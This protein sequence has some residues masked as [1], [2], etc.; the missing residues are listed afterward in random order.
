M[1]VI[2]DSDI[3]FIKGVI[4]TYCEVVYKK[5]E[6]ITSCDVKDADALIIRTRTKCTRSLLD[7]SNVRFIASATIGSDHVDLDYCREHG[8][9][10]TNAAGC[11]AWGVVQYVVTAI[12]TMAHLQN[13]SLKGK[14][15]GV[16]G[17]GNVGERVARTLELLGFDVMRCDPPV[18]ERLLTGYIPDNGRFAID[19]SNLS[20]EDFHDLAHL[21]ENSDVVS[22]HLPLDG[23]TRG[24]FDAKCFGMMKKGAI[25]I[26][27]SRGEV[28]D[29]N[30][31]LA[32]YGSLSSVIL[33]VWAGEPKINRDLQK[34]VG[35]GTPH[36][37]GYSLEGKINATVMSVNSF[38]KFFGIEPLSNF[39]IEYPPRKQYNAFS[40][41][42]VNKQDWVFKVMYESFPIFDTD[43]C[44]R[45][46]PESFE[47]LRS[48]YNYR[49]EVTQDMYEFISKKYID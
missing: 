45:K 9:F 29:E 28:L 17:A 25:F 46:N 4:E 34:I 33:D 43:I 20:P 5:G 26:N 21:L 18:R 15:I 38:G 13:I 22:L 42:V 1:K 48:S 2:I 19:R 3:P 31:L 14:R 10:F 8:I 23:S 49:R 44:L 24:M 16:V 27:A 7:G 39:S 41:E 12:F 11:N 37:A 36:I 6:E 35:I 47:K 30:A 40:T 32:A